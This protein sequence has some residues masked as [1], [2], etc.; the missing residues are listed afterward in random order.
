M[1]Q[2][3][4]QSLCNGG[5]IM[6]PYPETRKALPQG[7]MS[8]DLF[9]NIVDDVATSSSV[10]SVTLMLQNEP[11]LDKRLPQ[12]I[13]AVRSRRPDVMISLST[14]GQ[15]LTRALL[16]GLVEAGLTSLVFSVNALRPDT[17][18]RI[19]PGLDYDTVMANLSDL[20]D[21]P[22]AGLSVCVKM[23]VVSKNEAEMA[24]PDTFLGFVAPLLRS[25]IKVALD[26]ISN[27]AGSLRA[28]R[29]LLVRPEGQSSHHKTYCDDLFTSLN[30][31]FNGDVIGCC[32]DWERR[33][34]LGNL[35][36]MTI[37]EVWSGAEAQ[38]RRALV[39]ARGYAG[40]DPCSTCSQAANI[41]NAATARSLAEHDGGGPS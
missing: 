18:L 22:P 2:I 32:A 21:D 13:A 36:A 34:V 39:L 26:P 8:W 16:T 30:I 11:L 40:L 23:L 9:I 27:R 33:G 17:F 5:C 12:A 10:G 1:V 29:D 28:Y 19:E 20:A 15:L 14:N 37:D 35:A 31:L 41:I 4:T 24:S 7:E 3:Q 25:G 6:C 38:R